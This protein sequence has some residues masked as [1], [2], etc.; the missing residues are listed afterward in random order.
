MASFNLQVFFFFSFWLHWIF[1]GALRF[2]LVV[3]SRSYSVAVV[4]SAWVFHCGGFCCKTWALGHMSFSSCSTQT[5]LP[6]GMWHLPRPGIKP[7][8]P[9]LTDGLL[10]TG[11][12]GKREVPGFPSTACFLL[13]LQLLV[14]KKI[15]HLSCTL[16]KSVTKSVHKKGTKVHLSTF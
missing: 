3:A 5:E 1:I 12:P 14:R 15:C 7:V 13:L 4:G 8:S 9:P 16:T 6:R 2:S 10:T 11:L